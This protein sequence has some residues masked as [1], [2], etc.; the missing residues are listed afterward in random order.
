MSE[1]VYPL[2]NKGTVTSGYGPRW[3]RMHRGVDI[4]VPDGTDVHAVADGVVERSDINDYNGYGN[5][6]CIKHDDIKGKTK[7]SC[8]AHLTKRLVDVGD[9][10]KQGDLIAKSGGGQGKKGGS[11]SSTGP[12]L[13]FEIRNTLKGDWENPW[14]YISGGAIVKGGTVGKQKTKKTK[15][16]GGKLFGGKELRMIAF[17]KDHAKRSTSDWQSSH[18]WDIGQ[19]PGTPVYSLTS[20]KVVKKHES[21]G[22]KKNIFGTQISIKGTDG[23]PD[24]FY[25]HLEGVKPNIGDTV[26][27]GDLIGK[28]TRWDFAPKS[29]HVHIGISNNKDIFEFMDSKGNIKNSTA[30]DSDVADDE[31][32]DDSDSKKGFDLKSIFSKY[33][34]QIKTS[35]D[36]ATSEYEKRNSGLNEEVN[37]IKDIFKKIL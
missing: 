30:D 25:T 1:L 28:I 16:A 7:F 23:F 31:E 6:I 29:S 20:G 35:L 19:E 18:A 22:S 37:R 33:A 32:G 14:P 2:A 21:S 9:E 15:K 26:N 13:H 3:G 17:P 10:V 11:G 4:G 8:Y 27:P 12:H 36:Y 34:P 24:I 5:F